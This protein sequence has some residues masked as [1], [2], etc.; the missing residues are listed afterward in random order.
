MTEKLMKQFNNIKGPL[1]VP[2]SNK[3]YYVYSMPERGEKRKVRVELIGAPVITN[4]EKFSKWKNTKHWSVV[5]SCQVTHS[6]PLDFSDIAINSHRAGILSQEMQSSN[7]SCIMS[8]AWLWYPTENVCVCVGG[9]VIY[10]ISIRILKHF[11][12]C[13]KQNSN[14]PRLI[15]FPVWADINVFSLE[16]LCPFEVGSHHHSVIWPQKSQ[17]APMLQTRVVLC[18]VH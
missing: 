13:R 12:G 15:K 8:L 14:D 2:V 10:G 16:Q 5:I 1:S 7:L 18:N 9:G 3:I 4:S 6:L 17:K 11:W